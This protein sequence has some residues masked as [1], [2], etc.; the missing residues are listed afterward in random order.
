MLF[1]P[2]F[3]SV[4]SGHYTYLL[5][6]PNNLCVTAASLGSL[7]AVRYDNGILCKVPLRALKIYSRN[8][9]Y[10]TAP[11]LTVDAWFDGLGIAS[12]SLNPPTVSQSVNFHAT[13][14][15]NW[16]LKQGY[17]LPVILSEG[18]VSYRMSLSSGDDM[19]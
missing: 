9:D 15:S 13:G 3:V 7:E 12:Q 14:G 8:L 4:A 17:S 2:G 6:A 5:S 18:D 19:P 16:P 1:P 10:A 11:S